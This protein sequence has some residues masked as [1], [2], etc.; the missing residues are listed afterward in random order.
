VDADFLWQIRGLQANPNAI[1]ELLT[2]TI[3]IKTENCDFASGARA[4]AFQDLDCRRF[5]GTVRSQ[6]AENFSGPNLEVDPFHSMHFAVRLL[7]T[8]HGDRWR[9]RV[10]GG[11][12]GYA[13]SAIES[14]I[15]VTRLIPRGRSR[16]AIEAQPVFF[17]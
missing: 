5:S 9:S 2:L 6:Q 16:G 17:W 3:R 15:A 13:R 10:H 7:Q 1:L 11:K 14:K 8:L 12:T 4:Q